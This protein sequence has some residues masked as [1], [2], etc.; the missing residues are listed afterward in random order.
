[1][2]SGDVACW[3]PMAVRGGYGRFGRGGVVL[4]GG[5]GLGGYGD[6]GYEGGAV[7]LQTCVET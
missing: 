1:M 4:V 5:A 7:Q 2:T 6:Y 3:R